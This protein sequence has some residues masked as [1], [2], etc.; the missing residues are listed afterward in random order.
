MD[1]AYRDGQAGILARGLFDG[2]ACPVCGSTSH[3]KLAVCEVMPPSENELKA[4]KDMSEQ[5]HSKANASAAD[6]QVV[7]AGIKDAEKLIAGQF[8]KIFGEETGEDALNVE[9]LSGKTQKA[10]EDLTAQIE[11]VTHMIA[12]EKKKADRRDM[13]DAKIPQEEKVFVNMQTE[14]AELDKRVTAL[15]AKLESDKKQCDE[16]AVGLKFKDSAAAE[17]CFKR[18]HLDE[19]T[20]REN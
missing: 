12:E 2:K 19:I 9:E 13:L 16:L 18:L 3:P 6:T 10:I 1:Q 20:L 15:Q 4:A 11:D 5:A 8:A 14:V 17:S 7:A